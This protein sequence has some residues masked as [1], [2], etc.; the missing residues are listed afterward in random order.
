[1]PTWAWIPITLFAVMMQTVRTA[2]QK[3]LAG[4]LDPVTVT[5]VR[6]L[7]GLPFVLLYL[8][9]VMQAF[10]LALPAFNSTF[11]IF[12]TLSALTQIGAT[13]LLIYLFSLRNFAVGTTYA[14]TEAFLTALVGALVFGEFISPLGWLAI[15]IS[16]AGLVILTMARS[17]IDGAHLLQ[18]LFSRPALVGLGCGLLFA[19]CSLSLRRAS[20]SFGL[21][22]ALFSAGLTLVYMV[23]LQTLS[24]LAY[25]LWRRPAQLTTMLRHT[26]LC[27]FVGLTSALGSMG[28]FVAMTLERASYVK[29]LGQIEF[30]LALGVSHLFFREHTQ[31]LELAG[32]LLIA[33]GILVLLFAR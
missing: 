1:M 31:R 7:F 6:Y 19:V 9:V 18:R 17:D 32:M 13:I 22:N 29:A 2:G 28:W 15:V 25:L 24:M 5:L 11:L 26:R 20:L 10:D 30:L 8:L 16:V 21:D 33:S 14:R 4:H 23:I 12:A 27:G 3:Q